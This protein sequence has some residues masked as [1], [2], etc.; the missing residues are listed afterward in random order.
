[1]GFRIL[2]SLTTVPPIS[3]NLQSARLFPEVVTEKLQKE[4]SLGRMGGLF[5]SLPLAGLIVSPLGVVPKKEPS[6][7]RL[8]HHLSHPKVASVNN[9]IDPQ[10]C[11]VTYTSF[12]AAVAW[13]RRYG[14]GTL[15]AKVDVE[16]A[17]RLLPVHPGYM[18]LLGCKWQGSY[19]V[20]RCLPMGCSISC[21]LFETFS[22]FVEWVVREV[23]GLNSVIHYLDDFLCIGPSDSNACAVLLGTLQHV[24][25]RFGIPL[26]P[27]KTVGPTTELFFWGITIDSVAMEC[28]LPEAKLVALRQEVK[29]MESRRKVRVKE[30][31]VPV[32]QIKFCMQDY[33]NGKDILSTAFVGPGGGQQPQTFRSFDSRSPS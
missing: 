14:R 3:D 19:F 30:P 11:A 27:E 6:K 15:L 10:V 4:V 2:C 21:A 12:D 31:A 8:I 29:D 5:S 24:A 23:S 7:F 25:A 18:H 17:F 26:A 16:S 13:V 1:M 9:G 28:R 22:S 20:D 33:S 32:G